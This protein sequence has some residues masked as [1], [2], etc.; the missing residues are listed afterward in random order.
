M[1]PKRAAAWFRKFRCSLPPKL[2]GVFDARELP[3]SDSIEALTLAGT[4][5]E[6]AGSAPPTEGKTVSTEAA[7]STASECKA[8]T[9]SKP[10]PKPTRKPRRISSIQ[11]A[12]AILKYRAKHANESIRIQDI[13]IET[14]CSFQNLY[15]SPDFRK[16]WES[17]REKR[18]NRGWKVGGIADRPD[19]STLDLG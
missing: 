5:P 4:K 2:A 3:N 19:N 1:L 14:G 12:I 11:R 17:A 18:I 9:P 7:A 15:K 16:E 6:A 13:A 8:V 10:Q